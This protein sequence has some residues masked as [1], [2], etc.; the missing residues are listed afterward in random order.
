MTERPASA[1][2]LRIQPPIPN[3]PRRPSGE[4]LRLRHHTVLPNRQPNGCPT[5]AA[6]LP[7]R[8][9]WDQ[10]ASPLLPKHKTRS[11]PKLQAS[12]LIA[13]W[14]GEAAMVHLL[15]T[16]PFPDTH[17]FGSTQIQLDER[18]AL[19]SLV[20]NHRLWFLGSCAPSVTSGQLLIVRCEGTSALQQPHRGRRRR[21]HQTFSGGPTISMP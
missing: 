3:L 15:P 17:S 18:M 4:K 13:H 6:S 2:S 16:W 8:L 12:P 1:S 10:P 19:L 14:G 5:L 7:L 11:Q 9:G 20:E 21:D